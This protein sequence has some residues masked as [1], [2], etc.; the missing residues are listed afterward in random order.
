MRRMDICA[1][2]RLGTY[3]TYAVDIELSHLKNV[4]ISG[5][6][7]FVVAILFILVI[8]RTT[9]RNKITKYCLGIE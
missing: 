5:L 6:I 7:Q 2:F 3:F 1:N 4:E 8:D 9:N